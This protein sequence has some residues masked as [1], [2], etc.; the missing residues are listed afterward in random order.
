MLF[1]FCMQPRPSALRSRALTAESSPE[2]E[3]DMQRRKQKAAVEATRSTVEQAVA[4][5]LEDNAG[6]H[7]RLSPWESHCFAM[8]LTFL[9]YGYY[10]RAMDQLAFTLEPPTPLPVFPL[11]NLMTLEQ[12]RS[13][14]PQAPSADRYRRHEHGQGRSEDRHDGA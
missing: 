10:E 8:L 3:P 2:F 11:R 9:R 6:D 4:E 1:G 7:R 13:A 5:W 14:F 12:V